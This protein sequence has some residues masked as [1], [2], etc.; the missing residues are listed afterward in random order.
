MTESGKRGQ[1]MLILG[2]IS[3]V[4]LAAGF[5]LRPYWNISKIRTNPPW[6]LICTAISMACFIGMIYLMDIKG[7][8]SRVRWLKPAGTS[9]LTSYLLPYIHYAILALVGAGFS[10]PIVLRT[11]SIGIIKS[12]LY[13]GLI[14][15]I[16][17]VLEKRRI[18]L[19]I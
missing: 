4:L 18:R 3:L 1:G 5:A 19:S 15:Y 16:T 14:V 8:E 9:T 7:Q 12:L 2:V 13:A 6:V 10:L 11:G 17:G